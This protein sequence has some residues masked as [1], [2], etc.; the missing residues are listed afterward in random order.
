MQRFVAVVAVLLAVLGAGVVTLLSARVDVDRQAQLSLAKLQSAF[1]DLQTAPNRALALEF[2]P[3]GAS[4]TR[5]AARLLS[6]QTGAAV[7]QVAR[8]VRSLETYPRVAETASLVS[9]INANV[10]AHEEGLAILKLDPDL[11]ASV[12]SGRA[13]PRAA[14]FFQ[15]TQVT[16]AAVNDAVGRLNGA[17]DSRAGR[18]RIEEI[19]GVTAVIML[20]LVA[21]G[22]YY[23]RSR[24]LREDV[25]RLLAESRREAMSDALTGL[26][27]RRALERD[28]RV[29]IGRAGPDVELLVV[30]YD[31]DGFKHYNDTFGHPAGDAVLARL[32]GN[33]RAATEGI[34]TAYRLGGDEFCL[35]AASERGGLAQLGACGAAALTEHGVGF[36]ISPSFGEARLPTEAGDAREALCLADRR[37]YRS[38]AGRRPSVAV[39]VTTS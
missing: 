39:A 27:N 9:M 4:D 31:L 5:G 16:A 10:A 24:K 29:Q 30:V 12:L 38:K 23:R 22:F 2:S 35:L 6:D 33:L 18:A 15:H 21:F 36:E 26:A 8:A 25:E 20:L 14:G 7:G 17:Y 11:L 3:R 19:G 37:M 1:S 28:L 13:A 34:A 32:G